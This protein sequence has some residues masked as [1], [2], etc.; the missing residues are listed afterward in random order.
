MTDAS[1]EQ[2]V[3]ERLRGYPKLLKTVKGMIDL[4]E[5]ENV[6]SVDDFEEA[7]IPQVRKLGKAITQTWASGKEQSMKSNLEKASEPHH[8]KKNSIGIRPLEK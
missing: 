7:L 5:K 2:E 3:C 1:E 6:E 4:I 8:S